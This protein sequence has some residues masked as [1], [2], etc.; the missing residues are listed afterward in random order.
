V[1][2]QSSTWSTVGPRALGPT[3]YQVRVT[4]PVGTRYRRSTLDLVRMVPGTWYPVPY[5]KIKW[6]LVVEA[7]YDQVGPRT[8][9]LGPPRS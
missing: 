5:K 3:W 7:T 2:T 6:Y 1:R 9:A 4:V 8:R